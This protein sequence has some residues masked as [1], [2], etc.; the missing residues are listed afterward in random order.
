MKLSKTQQEVLD[1]LKEP[2]NYLHFMEYM[3]RFNPNAYYFYH[4]NIGK[5]IRFNTV[6]VLLE[7]GLVIR[8]EL[9]RFGGHTIWLKRL[10][11]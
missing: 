11:G 4:N 2:G 9:D 6:Q 3:G 5:R 7:K 10:S 8:K 1:I